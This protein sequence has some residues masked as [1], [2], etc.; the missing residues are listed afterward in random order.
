MKTSKNTGKK[1]QK[2]G[3]KMSLYLRM[4]HNENGISK[5]ELARRYPQYSGRSIRRHASKDIDDHAGKKNELSIKRGRKKKLTDRDERM[6]IS[7]LLKLRSTVRSFTAKRI[8]TEANLLHVSTRTIHRILHKHGYR[9]LQSRKKGLV[10]QADRVNRLKF[11]KAARNFPAN[12]WT[13][14]VTFYFDGVGFAHK[15]HPYEEARS[16]PS[17]AWRKRSEGLITSTKGKKEG[18]GGKMANFFVA[19]AHGKGVVFC[20]QYPWVLTGPR[21]AELVSRCFPAVFERCGV[22]IEGS[23]FLQDGDPRQNSKVVKQALEKMGCE[24]FSIP[25]RSP[26]LN[27][28]ENIFHLVRDQL[29]SDALEK[30]IEHETYQEFSKRVAETICVFSKE[31]IDKTIESMPK[32]IIMVIEKKGARTKY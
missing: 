28:I 12:F 29:K 11:S 16:P 8:Q 22:P 10:T 1:Y 6:V 4:L 21:F 19:I 15:T 24:I 25:P 30:K 32:R 18:S 17:M 7:T 9:F 13:E 20:K 5:A 2:I 31:I 26:D 27:P 23:K 14:T 3:L